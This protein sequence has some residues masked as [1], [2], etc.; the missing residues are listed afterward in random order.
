MTE[1]LSDTIKEKLME[2]IPTGRLGSVDDI[3]KTALF[4]AGDDSDYI[5]AVSY[6][7]LAS[8]FLNSAHLSS[9]PKAPCSLRRCHLAV[10]GRTT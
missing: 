1:K 10:K 2:L 6:T 8:S 4:L 3:A 9:S 5:T 7:H